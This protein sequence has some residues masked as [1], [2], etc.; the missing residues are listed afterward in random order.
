MAGK[1]GTHGFLEKVLDAHREVSRRS[2]EEDVD[3]IGGG[4]CH[5]MLQMTLMETLRAMYT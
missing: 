1:L 2:N 3:D 5:R 4:E